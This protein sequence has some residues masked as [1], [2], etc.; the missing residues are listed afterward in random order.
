MS[1]SEILRELDSLKDARTKIEQK[2]SALEAQLR[3]INLRNNAATNGSSSSSYPTNG[4][5]QDMIHRYSRH[6]VLPSFGV[7]GQA[8]LLKASILVVGAGGLGAPALLYFAAS[9]VGR[10]GI[11]DHDVV[12]LNNMHR[13]IIHTEAYV[14]KPK[15]KSAAAACRSVNSSIQVVEHEEALRTSNAL[16]IL[17]KYDIIV[18]ATDNAP[19]RYMISDC[20]V[21]LGK[22][23]VSGAALGLEGQLTVYNYN[24]GPCYRCLFPTPPPRTACQS[25]ADGGVLGVVPGIIGC[26]Q[27]LEAIKLAASVGEPLSGRMLLLDA[28]SGRIRIVKIRGRSIHCEACGENA[29]FTQQHFREFDYENFTQTPLRVPP[30][31]LNLLPSESRISCKEYSEIILKKEPHVLV[32]VRPAHHFKIVSMPKSLNIPLSTLEARLPEISSALKKEEGD[33]GVV[34]ESSAQL[35]VVCRRGNDSQRAVQ[36]LHKMGFTS[37]KDIVGGLES[38]AHNVD[39]KF[40]TY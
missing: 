29:T 16:E 33:R 11:V 5:T 6:L 40:P 30:L 10:L 4:L 21:V 31:K 9:G 18:D 26:L 22:P 38:W 12:E 7:Q 2:I 24:G 37:A 39:P 17:S 1:A 19:T 28:L 34:S 23:L 35:Y 14:G 25:C 27:A 36:C 15:V 32:D 8:N 13:Q 3:E 20:C